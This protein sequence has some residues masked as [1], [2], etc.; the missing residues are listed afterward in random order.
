MAK[1]WSTIHQHNF[2]WETIASKYWKKYPN[3]HSSHVFSEDILSAE[4]NAQG[5]LRVKR[6]LSKTNKL[7]SWGEHL[8]KT[9]DVRYVLAFWPIKKAERPKN[10]TVH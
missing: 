9:R 8:F 10:F 7:P 2:D 1:Y 4:V 6:L 5:M 3:P